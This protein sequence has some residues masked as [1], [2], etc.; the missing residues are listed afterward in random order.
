MVLEIS[1]GTDKQKNVRQTDRQTNRAQYFDPLRGRSNN[2]FCASNR[3]TLGAR[4][5]LRYPRI[6]PLVTINCV[7]W[8]SRTL[9]LSNYFVRSYTKAHN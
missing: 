1:W 3:P 4:Q 8:L 6:T 9:L 5:T 7:A 2:L